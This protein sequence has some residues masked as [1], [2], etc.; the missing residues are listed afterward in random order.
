MKLFRAF[1]AYLVT[2][3]RCVCSRP[4]FGFC[5]VCACLGL[6][7]I[8]YLG[9]SVDQSVQRGPVTELHTQ[10]EQVGTVVQDEFD[11]EGKSDGVPLINV[12]GDDSIAKSN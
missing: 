7:T 12:A 8:W 9:S 1:R 6:G 2:K 10:Q 4:M 11:I 3:T 5:W